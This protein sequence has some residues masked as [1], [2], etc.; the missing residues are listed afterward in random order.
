MDGIPANEF[1]VDLGEPIGII[2]GRVDVSTIRE[3]ERNVDRIMQLSR[4]AITGALGFTECSRL[5]EIFAKPTMGPAA[6]SRNEIDEAIL[7]VGLGK[8]QIALQRPLTFILQGSDNF[9][10]K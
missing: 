9:D 3:V 8:V 7:R 10:G 6:L 4:L 2:R 5:I 1:E